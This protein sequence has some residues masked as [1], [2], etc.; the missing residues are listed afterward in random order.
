MNFKVSVLTL[1]VAGLI[2]CTANRAPDV[3]G[4]IRDSLKQA[5][6]NDVSVSQDRVWDLR[7]ERR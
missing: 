2:G 5:G 4:N 1:A 7:F 6:L 3:A